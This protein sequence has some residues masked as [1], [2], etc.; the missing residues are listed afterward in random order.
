VSPF[1]FSYL[2]FFLCIS[3]F[4]LHFFFLVTVISSYC[5]FILSVYFF[6]Y[7]ILFCFSRLERVESLIDAAKVKII[8]DYTVMPEKSKIL[9]NLELLSPYMEFSTWVKKPYKNNTENSVTKTKS[10]TI[11]IFPLKESS[12]LNLPQNSTIEKFS[13]FLDEEK[14]K[15]NFLQ[16][17]LSLKDFGFLFSTFRQLKDAQ[18][19]ENEV[20]TVSLKVINSFL[21]I[22]LIL[23]L[24]FLA[25][26][27]IRLFFSF[28]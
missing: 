2:I 14:E 24:I 11:Q 4:L 16:M 25:S 23:I 27:E 5:L 22:W 10:T 17:R 3:L 9:T 13:E 1:F 18:K 6:I 8:T 7:F 28:T 19:H 26:K 20:E 15:D 21:Q 12:N